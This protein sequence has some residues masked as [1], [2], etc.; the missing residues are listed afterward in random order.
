M[1]QAMNGGLPRRQYLFAAAAMVLLMTTAAFFWRTVAMAGLRLPLDPNEGWNAYHAASAANGA[2]LYPG[3]QAYLINNYPPLSF[4]I[5][6]WFGRLIGDAIFAGRIVSLLSFL[7]VSWGIFAAAGKMGCRKSESLFAA[8]LFA[9]GMLVF[10]DYVGM[11]DPQMLAHALAMA[12]FL[13]LLDTPHDKRTAVLA[14]LLFVLAFFVKHN[15]VAMAAAVTVWLLVRDRAA[16]V[17]L[18]GFGLSFALAGL[19][20]FR[21]I[22]GIGLLS[23]LSSARGYSIAAAVD[24]AGQWLRWSGIMLAGLAALLGWRRRDS[25][26]Q[27]CVLY[28]GFGIVLGLFFLGGAGVDA[29]ALFD[30]D[31]ALALGAGLALNRFPR[32]GLVTAALVVPI[33][34]G[35]WLSAGEGR[36]DADFWFRPGRDMVAATRADIAFLQERRGPALCAMLSLCYWS[37]KPAAV[38]VFN[39]GEAFKTGARDDHELARRIANGEFTVIQFDPDT[40]DPLGAR[41]AAAMAAHY[42]LDHTDDIGL[43]YVPKT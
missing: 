40:H 29:N 43:F 6:G 28:A 33:F 38:D 3:A 10:T 31:I 24:G 39:I 15:V 14:A 20:L 35:G 23:V 9:G 11:N 21:L 42:R 36:F 17:R 19:I 26:V 5:A 30:A 12:G 32:Q 41:V 2:P 22:Y 7:F 25:A 27:L 18:A 34:W 16:A 1:R 4:Y 13:L 37:N 8:A